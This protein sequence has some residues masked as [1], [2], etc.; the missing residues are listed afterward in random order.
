MRIDHRRFS[1]SIRSGQAPGCKHI[2]GIFSGKQRIFREC[3]SLIGDRSTLGKGLFALC[4]YPFACL[5]LQYDQITSGL[6]SGIFGKHSVGQAKCGNKP[7][8]FHQ[9]TTNRFVFRTVRQ[10]SRCD[11]SQQSAFL[12]RIKSFDKKVIVDSPCRFVF[13]R[14]FPFGIRPVIDDKISE[15]NIAGH[16][17]VCS[18]LSFFDLFEADDTDCLLR[19][20]RR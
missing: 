15:W 19:I 2:F 8:V 1:I 10:P 4:P 13:D 9:I 12:E 16:Q 17:I 18:H 6:C 14:I 5:L 3:F 20:I 7:A 11:E